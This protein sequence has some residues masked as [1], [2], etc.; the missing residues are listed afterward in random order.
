MSQSIKD[1][2]HDKAETLMSIPGVIGV[3]EGALDDGTPCLLILVIELTDHIRKDVPA[4]IGGYPVKIE[5]T[6]EIKGMSNGDE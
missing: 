4:D 5:V 6:G 3:G 2:I 1:L